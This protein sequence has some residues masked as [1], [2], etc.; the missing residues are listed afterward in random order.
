[1]SLASRVD[2]LAARVASE[3]K[4]VRAT[5]GGVIKDPAASSVLPANAIGYDSVGGIMRIGDGVNRFDR[6][7]FWRL[8]LPDVTPPNVFTVTATPSQTTILLSWTEAFDEGGISKYVVTRNGAAAVELPNTARSHT[9]SGLAATTAYAGQVIAYDTDGNQ[10]AISWSTTTTSQPLARGNRT[11][12][13]GDSITEFGNTASENKFGA[14]WN[15]SACMLSGQRLR[16]YRAKGFPGEQSGPIKDRFMAE[17]VNL[18]PQPDVVGIM[19]GTNDQASGVPH[20]TTMANLK[21]MTDMAKAAGILPFICKIPPHQDT[22]Q[23][24]RTDSFIAYLDANWAESAMID[25]NTPLK[26]GNG[27]ADPAL[28][29]DSTHPNSFGHFKMGQALAAAVP[30]IGLPAVSFPNSA[31]ATNLVS[32]KGTSTKFSGT[33]ATGALNGRGYI[34]GTDHYYGGNIEGVTVTAAANP[35][36]GPG[37]VVRL[38]GAPTNWGFGVSWSISTQG[39]ASTDR[40]FLGCR[41]RYTAPWSIGFNVYNGAGTTVARPMAGD[42]ADMFNRFSMA[43]GIMGAEIQVGGEANRYDVAMVLY[44]ADSGYAEVGEL[45]AFKL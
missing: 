30:A 25:T 38:A 27:L 35:W 4:Q 23:N 18:N 15:N 17:V 32:K 36:G 14:G 44:P 26:G 22:T 41:F 7:P 33:L 45:F 8:T 28:M 39:L 12:F 1:M 24:S 6:L 34:D 40:I 43:D 5:Q 21:S 10:R 37:R 3:L 9:I 13:I 42:S 20:A 11:A 2:A 31:A 16:M 19:A 29:S